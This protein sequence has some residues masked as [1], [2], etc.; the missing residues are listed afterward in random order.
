MALTN[1]GHKLLWCDLVHLKAVCSCT[2]THTY[3]IG[4]C[5]VFLHGMLPVA[6]R[7]VG[8]LM[9]CAASV[10]VTSQELRSWS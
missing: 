10:L 4:V 2:R 7:D 6:I 8:S 1:H 5:G 9:M 3:G